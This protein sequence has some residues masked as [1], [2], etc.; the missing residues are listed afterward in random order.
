MTILVDEEQESSKPNLLTFLSNFQWATL[1][2]RC[3]LVF[4]IIGRDLKKTNKVDEG[5]IIQGQ[6]EGAGPPSAS[7]AGIIPGR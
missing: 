5:S 6:H 1:R 4:L 2:Y 3:H 7:F